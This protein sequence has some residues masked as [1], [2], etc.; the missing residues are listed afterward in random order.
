MS[1][2]FSGKDLK[3]SVTLIAVRVE[4]YSGYKADERPLRFAREEGAG[5]WVAVV[6]ILRQWYEPDAHCFVIDAEDGKGCSLRHNV[7][8]DSW[9]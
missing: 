5:E 1:D 4:C 3:R 6:R 7:A 2:G 9:T 8:D